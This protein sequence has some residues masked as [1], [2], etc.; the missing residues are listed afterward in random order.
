[1][2]T[3]TTSIVRRQPERKA[4]PATSTH[5]QDAFV[6]RVLPV[7]ERHARIYFRH[8][9]CPNRKA[10]LIAE[11]VGLAWKWFRRLAHRGKDGTL[12]P[13]AIATFAAKSVNS[14]RRVAGREKDKDVL[15]RLAQ[16]KRGFA[17]EKLPDFSTLRGNPLAEAL[18]DNTQSPV[19]D[20]AA[21]R[22]DFP[23][24]LG[25]FDSR[26]RALVID[27]ALGHRTQELAHKYQVSEGRISQVRRE[28]AADWQ[29]FHGELAA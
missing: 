12:F 2:S 26:R 10:D 11:A 3:S 9:T 27:L 4:C 8:I 21:F 5:L 29:R 24:W 20:Q 17:V 18:H 7:V 14:G 28:A 15:S 22:I 23:T 19:A 25:T 13:T 16:H 1:M 6:S